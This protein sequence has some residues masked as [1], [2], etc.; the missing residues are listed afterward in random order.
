ME[1]PEEDQ[2]PLS[3]ILADIVWLC[4]ERSVMRDEDFAE[5][6]GDALEGTGLEWI[7]KRF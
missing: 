4:Y 2:E 7:C 5:V 3:A 1:L 6:L